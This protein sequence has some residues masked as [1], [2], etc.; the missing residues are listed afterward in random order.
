MKKLLIILFLSIG[1]QGQSQIN[2]TGIN[3]NLSPNGVFETVFDHYGN[4]YKISDIIVGKTVTD[5]N[6]Q[7][8]RTTNP[9]PTT[10]GYFNLYF[11][12]GC[13]MDNIS[14]QAQANRRNVVC[15]VFSDLSA[16]INLPPNTPS[17]FRV[18]IWVRNINNVI[19]SPNTPNGVLGL[20]SSFY[21]M[22]S[23]NTAGFG[24]IIDSEIW[25]SI[26]TGKNSY[27]NVASPLI[28]DGV[29]VGPSGNLYHGMMAFNF[30]TNN[31]PAFSWNTN[32]GIANPSGLVDLYSVVLH[33]VIHALG[34][35]SLINQD[36]GSRLG[37]GFNYFTRY[38]NFLRNNASSQKLITN[39]GSCSMYNYNFNSANLLTGVLHPNCN[40]P[41][42]INTENSVGTTECNNAL[43]YVGLSNVPIYTPVCY[44]PG[45]S[46]SHFEDVCISPPNQ[47]TTNSYF[48]M[49]DATGLGQTKRFLRP[50][51]RNVLCDIGYNVNP[52]FGTAFNGFINYGGTRP[53]QGI[54]VAGLNDGIDANNT[55]TF[56]GNAGNTI[57]ISGI[58]NNDTGA[59]GFEC[60][61]DVYSSSTLSPSSGTASTTI[62]FTNGSVG[63]HLLRY[64]PVN[65]AQKGN[66]T[67]IYVYVTDPESN[68]ASTNACNLVKN[69]DFEQNS[70]IPSGLGQI[71]LACGWRATASTS[72]TEYIY[73][74]SNSPISRQPCHLVG[75]QTS[76]NLSG[77][78][79]AGIGFIKNFSLLGGVGG[80]YSETISTKLASALQPNSSYQLSFDVSL[81]EGRSSA[82]VKFQAYLG[83]SQIAITG[84]SAIPISNPNM[85]KENNTFSTST[86]NWEKV[87]INFRTGATAGEQYLCIGLLSNDAAFQSQSPA[88]ANASCLYDAITFN[89]GVWSASQ[90][91]YYYLDNVSLVPLNQASLLLP[92]SVCQTQI[93]P[94]LRAFLSPAPIGGVFTGTAGV[95]F[96][97]GL[98]SF[99]AA[100]AGP[101]THTIKYRY[102]NN[103]GCLISIYSNITVSPC[104]TGSCPGNLIFNTQEPS[105]TATY[106]ASNTIV[107][108]TNYLVNAGS[109]ITL[110]AGNS[111]TFSPNSEVKSN[112]TSN[113]TARLAACTQTS[114]KMAPSETEV[115]V[116]KELLLFPNPANDFTTIHLN[117]GEFKKV[118]I[119]TIEGRI[120]LNEAVKETSEYQYN[121]SP[122]TSGIYIVSIETNDGEIISKKL[123]KR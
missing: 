102:T 1:L 94:D 3:T 12:S 21:T 54:S 76:N 84:Y 119:T 50:E 51:E 90:T 57:L 15:Q 34:F 115:T 108:N 22:P 99:N 6:G 66:I 82:A 109:T 31:I 16:F 36:G 26:H 88:G 92:D 71:S 4:A 107:T 87:T 13:G 40:L 85:L 32:T 41:N 72:S 29:N 116:N 93:F 75:Y 19:V 105:T 95:T 117:N 81:A 11:E 37:N 64:V 14:I 42:N 59:T 74:T 121:T 122:L 79:F 24:G 44:E 69:G 58:L 60:L 43:R 30:N 33:E 73:A 89:T 25:K 61:E 80:L 111:I 67:Y 45:S 106:Q 97:G 27:A 78:G 8:L 96:S 23:N 123:I 55:Y 38:D 20:A 114:A 2:P 98:Y 46:F 63:L 86:A 56:I 77:N 53:C 68:C 100:L 110:V 39:S 120:V 10:C 48:V 91:T 9:T 104:S 83:T 17:T 7:I 28:T 5:T 49:T 103:L 65:G 113:F 52:T 35:A 18:N 112:S 70:A 118:I 62:N 101:G 47:N